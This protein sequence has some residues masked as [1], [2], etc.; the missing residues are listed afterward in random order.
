MEKNRLQIVEKVKLWFGPGGKE[1]YR[2]ASNHKGLLVGLCRQ[3][4]CEICNLAEREKL[5]G[6]RGGELEVR[7]VPYRRPTFWKEEIFYLAHLIRVSEREAVKTIGADEGIEFDISRL[8]TLLLS[9]VKGSILI[10]PGE[11]GFDSDEAGFQKLISG[12]KIIAAIITHG[13]LDH[14]NHLNAL[15]SGTVFMS[16]LTFQLASR[17]ASWQND[18]RLVI[19]LRRAQKISPGE[20]LL[21]NENLP[22]KIDTFSLPHSIPETMGLIIKGRKK[23]IVHLGDFK[24]S[25]MEVEARDETI[26]RFSQIAEEPV[27]FLSLN[28]VN[29][30]L[31]GFT[32]IEAKAVEAITDI[33]AEAKGRVIITSFST[34]LERIRRLTEVAK[35]LGREVHFFGAGMKNAKEFLEFKQEKGADPGKSV[36]FITGCQAEEDS[37]LWRIAYGEDLKLTFSFYPTDTLIFSSRCVPGNES[38]LREQIITLRPKVEKLVVNEGEIEQIGLQ[39]IEV[40]EA[41]VHVSGH[42]NKEDLR[43]V[44]EIFRPKKVLPWPQISPQIEAF[45]EITEPLGIEVLPETERVIE[46]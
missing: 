15:P 23:R 30:H 5:R 14:W 31:E 9:T 11:M 13:H 26:S 40:E 21:L 37:V 33:M 28:I 17:H 35:M 43:L 7:L 3:P 36:V 44:L 39:D 2:W 20:P 19:A 45:R 38:D 24:L 4:L 1:G 16:K 34:N 22:I 18:S 29:A 27:D 41:P 6:F 8:N 42:G 10:D 46:T 25:G 12:R 32:P